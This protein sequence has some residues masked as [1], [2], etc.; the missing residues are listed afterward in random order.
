VK[1]RWREATHLNWYHLRGLGRRGFDHFVAVELNADWSVAGAWLLSY[2]EVVEYRH[3]RRDGRDVEPTKLSVR[4][5]WKQLARPLDLAATQSR[6]PV[7]RRPSLLARMRSAPWGTSARP[8]WETI[9]SRCGEDAYGA[10]MAYWLKGA[11]TSA[12]PLAD[13]WPSTSLLWR[14]AF[15]GASSV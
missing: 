10:R 14:T 15:L 9:T 13:D 3:R 7:G 11:G 4:G 5:E 1:S 6:N 8:L 12:S 2:D